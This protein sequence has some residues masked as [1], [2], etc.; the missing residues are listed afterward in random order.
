MCS[1]APAVVF[2]VDLGK[3]DK[4]LFTTIDTTGHNRVQFSPLLCRNQIN[5]ITAFL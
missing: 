2:L 3:C 5:C 1:N 4:Y